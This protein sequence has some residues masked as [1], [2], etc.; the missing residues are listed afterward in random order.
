MESKHRDCVDN[1]DATPLI[2]QN[3]P[4]TPTDEQ[5]EAALNVRYCG[6]RMPIA[7]APVSCGPDFQDAWVEMAK[8]KKSK[9][10]PSPPLPFKTV[11]FFNFDQK[12]IFFLLCSAFIHHVLLTTQVRNLH[13]QTPTAAVQMPFENP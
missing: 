8:G 2:M 5:L 12:V 6:R 3:S 4:R 1:E 13:S 7:H 10:I 11:C 9:T